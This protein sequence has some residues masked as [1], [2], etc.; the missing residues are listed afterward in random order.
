MKRT[1]AAA[2][3]ALL[4]VTA[5]PTTAT[6]DADVFSG[7]YIIHGCKSLEGPNKHASAETENRAF[8]CL[9]AVASLAIIGRDNHVIC[10]PLGVSIDD[11]IKVAVKYMD[12]HPDL[13]NRPFPTLINNSLI[14]EWPC[15]PKSQ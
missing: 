9:G 11:E 10:P 2:I 5:M 3:L 6:A 12:D 1:F 14:A 4:A 8:E 13:Q 15:P 7:D